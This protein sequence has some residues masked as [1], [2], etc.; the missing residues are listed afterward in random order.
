[1]TTRLLATS[2]LIPLMGV[3][4]CADQGTPKYSKDEMRQIVREVLLEEPEIV[5]D[6]L[7]E[8]ERKEELAVFA[9]I[10]DDLYNT[11]TDPVIGPKDA[12][13]TI[14]EFFDY[15][16]GFCKQSTDWLREVTEKH[17][18]DVRVIF[19]ELPILDRRTN[20]SRYASLAALAADRQ[21]KYAEMHF[22]LMDERALSTA[23]IDAV[24]KEIGLDMDQYKRDME[25]DV[26][27]ERLEENFI[28]ARRIPMFSGTPFFIIGEG[29]VAGADTRQLDALLDEA[30]N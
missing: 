9:A 30:L 16:C 28:T 10:E 12:K 19:K 1:M 5:R 26:L 18:K 23:R 2:L 22:A 17:P 8:L 20:T 29:Y 15:N 7:E 6:A 25:D 24:A 4:A 27:A 3:T 13:V 14:V 11:S 21:G